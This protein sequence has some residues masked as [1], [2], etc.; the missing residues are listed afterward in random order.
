[1]GLD[2]ILAR[3]QKGQ[4][5]AFDQLIDLFGDRLYGYFYRLCRSRVDAED[6]VQELFV[7]LVKCLHDYKHQDQ[8]EAF[9]FR[10][11][12]N[13]YR[14]HLRRQRRRSTIQRDEPISQQVE[15]MAEESVTVMQ[16]DGNLL[17]QEQAQQLEAALHTLPGAER[18]VIIL[19][20]YSEL[21]F[22]EIADIMQTPLGTALARAHRGLTKLRALLEGQRHE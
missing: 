13:L 12:T 7:R 4:P 17:Q 21:S 20:H 11:A 15:E 16:P 9:L 19:R 5:Q 14:D 8:F 6:L 10:I 2:E 3:A 22:Q 1:M 18:E